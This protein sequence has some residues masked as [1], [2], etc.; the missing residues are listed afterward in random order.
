MAE[1]QSFLWLSNISKYIPH[2]THLS[3]DTDCFHI[4][5]IVNSTV[6]N[7]GGHILYF[8]SQCLHFVWIYDQLDHMAV[9]LVI[10]GGTF[11]LFSRV[12]APIY[13]PI[14]SAQG[15]AF[16]HIL[17]NTCCFCLFDDSH[18]NRCELI[19]HGGFD[20]HFPS[21]QWCCGPLHVSVGHLYIFF[22]SMSVVPLP[23]S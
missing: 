4:L 17:A 7:T 3:V 13:A 20:L 10:F 16:F 21:C 18:L 1:F 2:P 8:S 22:V 14:S 9:L 15:L 11:I 19:A 5:A 6:M 12:A 23:I